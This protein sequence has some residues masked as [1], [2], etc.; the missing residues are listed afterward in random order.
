MLGRIASLIAT[1]CRTTLLFALALSFCITA[2]CAT[3]SSARLNSTFLQ[4]RPEHKNWTEAQWSALFECF[5]RLQLSEIIVQWTAYDDVRFYAAPG[6]RSDSPVERILTSASKTGLKVWLGLYLDSDYWNHLAGDSAGLSAYMGHLRARSLAVARDL[7]PIVKQQPAFI[8]WYLP[9]EIDDLNWRSP[10]ARRE[11][12]RHL[13][14]ESTS[15]HALAPG[16]RVA[17]STFSNALMSPAQFRDFWADAF[18][19]S[20]VDMVLLQDAVGARKLEIS[21]FPLYAGALA[22]AASSAGRDFS[23]VVELF[24]QTGGP[25]LNSGPFQAAAAPWERIRSQIEIAHR[26]TNSMVAFS[27]PEYMSP[28]GMHGAEQLYADYLKEITKQQ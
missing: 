24:Q 17:I 7:A 3:G 21:E 20:S 12:L 22:A 26:F 13:N 9:E 15:L 14:L 18:R 23:V 27:I 6:E 2:L 19:A 28:T 1:A 25:P 11:L 5:Q 4:L 10:E 8:G 16:V